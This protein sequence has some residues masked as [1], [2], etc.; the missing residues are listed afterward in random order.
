MR[1]TRA[2]SAES[3]AREKNV[4]EA[5]TLKLSLSETVFQTKPGGVSYRTGSAR[6]LR[7][8]PSNPLSAKRFTRYRPTRLVAPKMTANGFLSH[9]SSVSGIMRYVPPWV[10]HQFNAGSWTFHPEL[11]IVLQPLSSMLK[12]T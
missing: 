6:R 12:E 9:L 7:H 10:C 3:G 2:G 11:V 5:G 4:V 8:K 1:P